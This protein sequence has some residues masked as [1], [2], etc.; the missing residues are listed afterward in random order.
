MNLLFKIVLRNILRN[1]R[2][3]IMT[4]SAVAAGSL[5]LLLFG[6]F[7]SYIFSGLETGNVQRNGHLTVFHSGY[8]L[9]GEGNPG[10]LWHPALSRSHDIDPG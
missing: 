6:G 7:T 2:R 3:S 1:R 10:R 4:G 8:F 5:A 9:F